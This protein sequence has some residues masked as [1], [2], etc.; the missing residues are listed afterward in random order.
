MEA[1]RVHVGA[2]LCSS[3]DRAGIELEPLHAPVRIKLE[4]SWKEAAGIRVGANLCS[5]PGHA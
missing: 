1:A 3:P 4:G 5:R 2:D